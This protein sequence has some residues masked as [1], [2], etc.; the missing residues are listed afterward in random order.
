M[1]TKPESILIT[2]ADGMLGRAFAKHCAERFPD[3]RLIARDHKGLDVSD[4]GSVEAI[5]RETGRGW[6]L[7]C[8]ALV[9]VEGCASNPEA[10]RQAIVAGTQNVIDLARR[11]GSKLL[12][13]QSFLTY[14]D[15][16]D[17]IPEDYPQ[18][19]LALYGQLKLEAQNLVLNQL[20]DALVVIMAGFFGGNEKDKNFVGKIIPQIWRA[21]QNGEQ[22][23][24]IGNRIWQPTWTHDLAGNSLDLMAHDKAGIYQMGCEGEASFFE[25]AEEI[26]SVMGWSDAIKIVPASV[27]AINATE[28]GRRPGRAV[29]SCSR[30][31]SEG[32]FNQRSWKTTLAEYLQDPYF[33]QF[34]AGQ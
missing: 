33:S 6:I 9:S 31:K 32:L 7:H 22:S 1:T 25:L 34:K 4:A 10:G 8:A 5:G 17:T 14:G 15:C 23:F 27:E 19:P 21:I 28:L 18:T 3:I 2:G 29:L 12:Y 16:D 11:T 13:P 30:L 26:V 20:P 24:A